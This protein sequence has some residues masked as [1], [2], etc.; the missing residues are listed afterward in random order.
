MVNALAP[1]LALDRELDLNVSEDRAT[2]RDIASRSPEIAKLLDT[3]LDD[4][5]ALFPELHWRHISW[6]GVV[7][8]QGGSY[9]QHFDLVEM[10]QYTAALQRLRGFPGFQC[11]VAG[12]RN[13]PQ[14]PSTLF[15]VGVADWCASR[16]V[17]IGLEFSPVVVARGRVKRPEF[18][19]Q[20]T[21]GELYAECK[22]GGEFE[23]KVSRR[24]TK[25]VDCVDAI[26][27]SY[28]PW[29]P[30]SRLEVRFTDSVK[31]G[32]E[33]RI[34]SVV[35][36]AFAALGQGM[37][38]RTITFQE[39]EVIG[40]VQILPAPLLHEDTF[41]GDV[42]HQAKLVVGSVAVGI[43][44]A[45]LDVAMSV[46]RHRANAVAHL[47]R[48][49]LTQLPEDRPSAIF[50]Q[51][52]GLGKVIERVQQLFSAPR[53]AQVSVVGL[54]TGRDNRLVWRNGQQFD[55]RIA[56]ERSNSSQGV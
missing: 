38:T 7:F 14:V 33:G 53:F 10:L 51:L 39:G 5:L 55:G 21:L 3:T 20:T 23:N 18:R 22:R 43:N 30:S 13:P 56:V 34:R 11:L 42:I 41:G 25:L 8:V 48:D 24:I 19:W 45:Y 28:G 2:L 32:V 16:A 54:F 37:P 40:T 26:Y 50:I 4:Y 47:M 36:R 9:S 27:K 29:L 49:A 12:F 44:D 52:Q 15:E 35:E 1:R 6:G 31:N 46:A 17:T